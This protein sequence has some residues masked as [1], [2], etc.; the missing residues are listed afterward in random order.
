MSYPWGSRR[1][2]SQIP[3]TDENRRLIQ[4]YVD[5]LAKER[6]VS[7]YL[8]RE[9]DEAGARRAEAQAEAVL[10]VIFGALGFQVANAGA[11]I[12]SRRSQSHNQRTRR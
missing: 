5:K 2:L 7:F 11:S 8:E 6:S 12:V 10:R 3:V 4:N 9:Y 1:A